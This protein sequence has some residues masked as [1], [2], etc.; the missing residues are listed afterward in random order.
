MTAPPQNKHYMMIFPS[1]LFTYEQ[2][3][4]NTKLSHCQDDNVK[5]GMMPLA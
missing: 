5:D 4:Q 3:Y 2:K 1:L